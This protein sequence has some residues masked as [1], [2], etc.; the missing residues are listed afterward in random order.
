M[1]WKVF[2]PNSALFSSVKGIFDPDVFSSYICVQQPDDTAYIILYQTWQQHW[3]YN[4][5]QGKG[6]MPIQTTWLTHLDNGNKGENHTQHY[7][8]NWW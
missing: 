1:K 3:F 2:N 5:N 8:I 4:L 6:I 7:E